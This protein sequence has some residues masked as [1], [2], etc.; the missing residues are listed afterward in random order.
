MAARKPKAPATMRE[1][2]LWAAENDSFH[3]ARGIIPRD[4]VVAFEKA[5][6]RSVGVVAEAS[7]R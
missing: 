2:R 5:T 7:E 6:H 3:G 4:V 1:V